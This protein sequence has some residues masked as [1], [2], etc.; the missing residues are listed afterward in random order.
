MESTCKDLILIVDDLPKNLQVLG[1]ILSRENYEISMAT[2][3]KQALS[4]IDKKLPDIVLL[5]IMMPGMD[6]F[7][8]AENIKSSDKSRH[9][10]IIFVSAKG[11]AESKVKGFEVGG[12]DY[13]T[14]PFQKSEVL[15]RVKTHL[16]LKK[17]MDT[18]NSY[19]HQLE[20][21]LE[22]RTKE[23]IKA[24][25]L[26]AFSLL[27]QGIVHNLKN[28]LTIISGSAQ[29]LEYTM[30]KE[31]NKNVPDSVKNFIFTTEKK[32]KTIT[33]SVQLMVDMINSLM[34]KSRNDK[35]E[36]IERIDI[37]EI[38]KTETDFLK[39]D[40]D[41]KNKVK[42]EMYFS[43]KKLIVEAVPGE[44]SQVFQNLVRNALDAMHNQTEPSIS[45]S[46][47]ESSTH[48]W[49][50]IKD[51]GPGIAKE[52]HEKVFDPFFTTKPKA[53]DNPEN[54]PTGTG[55]GLH[56]C[57]QMIK[58]YN[59]MIKLIS[60]PGK[61]TEFKVFLPKPNAAKTVLSRN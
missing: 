5:D 19:N 1:T 32:A 25:R 12:E 7:E 55:L 39:A 26:S 18:I 43:A 3:G 24:E 60:E 54:K 13:I 37:N 14:K 57:D 50:S 35:C 42:K 52:N 4:I 47:G 36:N 29:I 16:K 41:F 23:L 17:A 33:T 61:G 2:S 31:I 53:T 8:V 30:P 59:G 46:S 15:A 56:M 9:I 21:M 27:S 38:L 49:F 40:L 10:P 22:E 34:A 44:I 51:N 48:V 20:L 11:D 6:G 45:I 58:S 28:P